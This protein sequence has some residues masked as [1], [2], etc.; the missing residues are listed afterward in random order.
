MAS[1]VVYVVYQ[2]LGFLIH[3]VILSG[4]YESLANLWRSDEKTWIIW[5]TGLLWAALFT[6]IYTKGYEGKGVM[7]GVRYGLWIGL[8]ISIPMAFNLYAVLPVPASLALQWFIYGTLQII[9]CGTVLALVYRPTKP[10][11]SELQPT[12]EESPKPGA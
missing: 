12:A 10:P 4:L 7:E 9:I 11:V 3:E 8:F 6:F 1:I 2:I 5:L